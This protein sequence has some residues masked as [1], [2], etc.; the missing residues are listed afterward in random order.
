M[1]LWCSKC[2]ERYAL[3]MHLDLP[4]TRLCIELRKD[5]GSSELV[6]QYSYLSNLITVFD[7]LFIDISVVNN[8]SSFS[9]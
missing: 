6:N 7:S 9:S 5:F 1:A 4:E 8:H 2:S 3:R